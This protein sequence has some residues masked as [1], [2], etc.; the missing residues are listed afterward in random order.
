[1]NEVAEKL[2]ETIESLVNNN[3]W[4]SCTIQGETSDWD[5]F[6]DHGRNTGTIHTT[7]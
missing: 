7:G 5:S 1:M 4:K 6:N 3:L 2:N